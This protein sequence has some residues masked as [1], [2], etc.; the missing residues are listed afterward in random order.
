MEWKYVKEL[1]D[2]NKINEFEQKIGYELANDYKDFI[3]NFN[4]SRPMLKEYVDS[5]GNEHEI[6]T[7]LS[8]NDGDRENIFKVNEWLDKDLIGKYYAIASDPAGNYITIDKKNEI[9][10]WNHETGKLIYV[11]KSFTDFIESLK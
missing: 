8:F 7:F 5:E 6:K 1:K 2:V 4:G 10:F 9:Y 3:K 11:A